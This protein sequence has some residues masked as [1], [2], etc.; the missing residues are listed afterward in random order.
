MTCLAKRLDFESFDI[1]CLV[2][3]SDKAEQI[4]VLF[5]DRRPTPVNIITPVGSHDDIEF[6][7]NIVSEVDVVIAM[8][9]WL[10]SFF[11]THSLQ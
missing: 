3:S 4:Q 7:T 11:T 6:M 10:L 1:R 5:Q 8:V 9:G 2:R